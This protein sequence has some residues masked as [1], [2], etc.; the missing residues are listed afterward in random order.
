MTGK[1]DWFSGYT[2]YF[3]LQCGRNSRYVQLT[4]I[5]I[6]SFNE[7]YLVNNLEIEKFPLF[8]NQFGDEKIWILLQKR[9]L[10]NGFLGATTRRLEILGRGPTDFYDLLVDDQNKDNLLSSLVLWL[11]DNRTEW[12]EFEFSE[13]PNNYV[14]L[15]MWQKTAM[16]K[17]FKPIMNLEKGFYYV[18]TT[19]NWDYYYKD[20]IEPRN[21]DLL[22]DLR[23][24][25]RLGI[26]LR[27]ESHREDV[28][29]KLQSVLHLYAQRR[30][31]LGQVNS[32]ETPE[33]R[34]FV[35]D[36]IEGYEKNG[37]VELTFLKDQSEEIWAF[38]LDWVF[39]GVRYHWNHAYNEQFKKYSPGKI[40]LYMIMKRSFEDPN[41][42]ECNHMRGLAGYK[43]KL[44]NQSEPLLTIS[45]KN[46]YSWRN[47]WANIYNK[48]SYLKLLFS[49]RVVPSK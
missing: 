35:K 24:I 32:Y 19:E 2:E 15:N 3:H 7:N 22:K 25:K 48:L 1:K 39:E 18:N 17:R 42:R 9:F 26:D 12:D 28:Y 6:K 29:S 43:G 49:K 47:K 30:E 23:K 41:E 10:E 31:S 5:W 46:P 27:L 40:L 16:K 14:N 44:A 38:Q 11:Y 21:K 4:P 20:F 34:G 36:V 45:I 33:R 13:M 8:L 37:W